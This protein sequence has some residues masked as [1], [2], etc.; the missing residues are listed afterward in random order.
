MIA[1]ISWLFETNS[2]QVAPANQPFWY[3]SGYLGPYYINTHHLCGGP[4]K[5]QEILDFIDQH[6]HNRQKFPSLILPKLEEIYNQHTIYKNI[7]DL[8]CQ[9][10]TTLDS[11]LQAISGGQRR[12]WFFAPIVAKRLSL[13]MIYLY[14]D[15]QA[16]DQQG[17][18]ISQI[19]QQ[20]IANIADLLTIGSSYT[21]K[22]IP[23]IKKLGGQLSHS[24]NVVDRNQQGSQNLKNEGVQKIDHLYII[25]QD[26]FTQALNQSIINQ[27]EF[28]LIKNYLQDPQKTM[29][30]FLQ[31]NPEFLINSL[32]SPNQ[33]TKDR[34]QKMQQQRLYQL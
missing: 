31:N 23:A 28:E 27:A 33:K 18:L 7:I 6:S 11:K 13:P 3:T 20:K 1:K 5:A 4:T 34:A 21:S 26:L 30:K 9:K 10:L 15:Q 25:N 17:Q 24:L 14:N 2:L 8:L 22:W 16:T 19:K 29:Q 12:D 32:N